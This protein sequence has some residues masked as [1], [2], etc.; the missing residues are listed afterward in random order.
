MRSRKRIC[1]PVTYFFGLSS[2]WHVY[3]RDHIIVESLLQS[4][5]GSSKPSKRSLSLTDDKEDFKEEE[6]DV[7]PPTSKKKKLSGE[8]FQ[9]KTFL[10]FSFRVRPPLTSQSCGEAV[11][12]IL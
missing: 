12:S 6:E 1:E 8:L 2:A 5:S 9:Q 3:V 7:K 10:L 4:N 11:F